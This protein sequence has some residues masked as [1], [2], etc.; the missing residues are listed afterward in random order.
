VEEC[1]LLFR[2]MRKIYTRQSVCRPLA[3]ND[4]T[5]GIVVALCHVASLR[6]Q[7]LR[8]MERGMAE[9]TEKHWRALCAAAAQ[10]PDSEKVASLVNQILEALDEHREIIRTDRPSQS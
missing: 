2:H 4:L 1:P 8:V 5:S 6:G 7:E 9:S 10:E 3:V